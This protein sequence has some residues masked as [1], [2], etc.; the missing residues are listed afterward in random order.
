MHTHLPP[1]SWVSTLFPGLKDARGV[2]RV[3]HVARCL[4]SSV[5]RELEVELLL[6]VTAA[7]S[8][9]R[10]HHVRVDRVVQEG[11]ERALESDAS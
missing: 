9:V 7:C 4:L 11:V 6:R 8:L 5:Q 1:T 3:L 10:V 2:L